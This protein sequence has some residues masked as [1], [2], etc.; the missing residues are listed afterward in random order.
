MTFILGIWRIPQWKK[1]NSG[2]TEEITAGE[3]RNK[4]VENSL[5]SNVDIYFD[6]IIVL[7]T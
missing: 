4:N 3:T 5:E 2:G 6:F 7:N 1:E